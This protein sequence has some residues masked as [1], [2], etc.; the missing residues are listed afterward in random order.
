MFELIDIGQHLGHHEIEIHWDRLV[1]FAV[2]IQGTRQEGRFEHEDAVFPSDF[3][4]AQGHAIAPL[5]HHHR[6]SHLL[7]VIAQGHRIVGGIGQH[8]IGPRHLFHHA[9]ATSFTL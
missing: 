8:H 9:A 7:G 4:D 2:A 3:A 5:G 1:Q 6:R